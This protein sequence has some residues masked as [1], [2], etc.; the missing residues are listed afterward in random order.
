MNHSRYNGQSE[1][2]HYN[3]LNQNVAYTQNA[4][5]HPS[6][7]VKEHPINPAE[8]S[9]YAGSVSSY[10]SSTYP[11]TV[12]EN[13]AFP[14]AYSTQPNYLGQRTLDTAYG[15]TSCNRPPTSS[16]P[17]GDSHSSYPSGHI[18]ESASYGFKEP[19][20]TDD[21]LNEPPLLEGE[22]Y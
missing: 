13:T 2:Q 20:Y 6:A 8:P 17:M 21:M 14:T 9:W 10:V 1:E 4:G 7:Y 18:G 22:H 16:L 19:Q 5:Y 11:H 12:S 15:D 3:T